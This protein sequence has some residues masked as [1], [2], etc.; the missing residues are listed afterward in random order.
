MT[1]LKEPQE[2]RGVPRVSDRGDWD[3]VYHEVP[4]DGEDFEGV[5]YPSSIKVRAVA[6]LVV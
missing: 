1:I 6:I 4:A 2:I 3:T 5:S